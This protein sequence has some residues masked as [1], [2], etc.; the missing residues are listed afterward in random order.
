MQFAIS[1]RVKKSV[2]ARSESSFGAAS[3]GRPQI[4]IS[5]IGPLQAGLT[6]LDYA[7]YVSVWN[8]QYSVLRIYVVLCVHI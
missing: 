2:S 4:R 1:I 5:G 7:M 6:I 8:K 3:F